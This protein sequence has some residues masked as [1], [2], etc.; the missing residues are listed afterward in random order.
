M[1]IYDPTNKRCQECKHQGLCSVF[2]EELLAVM[3][4]EAVSQHNEEQ[5]PEP[6]EPIEVHITPFGVI[7][8]W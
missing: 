1:P 5:E 6:S 2:G 7:E 8:V 3:L 4:L